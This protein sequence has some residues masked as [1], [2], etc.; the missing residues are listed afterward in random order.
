VQFRTLPSRPSFEAYVVRLR[1]RPAY[2]KAKEIDQALMPHKP[3]GQ[4][5]ES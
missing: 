4:G 2:K 1:A 3:P 5:G